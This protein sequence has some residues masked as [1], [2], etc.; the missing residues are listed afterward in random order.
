MTKSLSNISQIVNIFDRRPQGQTLRFSL[1]CYCFNI[2]VNMKVSFLLT[3]KCR[4]ADF[5]SLNF[6][7]FANIEQTYLNLQT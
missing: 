5:K 1:V 6:N 7:Q 2:A 4:Q 3:F